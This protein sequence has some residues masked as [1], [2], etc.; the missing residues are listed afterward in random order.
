[1][2]HIKTHLQIR[3]IFLILLCTME[4]NQVCLHPLKLNQLFKYRI[5]SS[6]Q[7]NNDL[8]L[9]F[10]DIIRGFRGKT[11][12]DFSFFIKNKSNFLLS[13][14]RFNT[15]C[16][17][18]NPVVSLSCVSV[19]IMCLVYCTNNGGS[20]GQVI[21]TYQLYYQLYLLKIKKI[22]KFKQY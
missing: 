14:E 4:G 19:C 9:N 7:K 2:N 3:S 1:M 18:I 17:Q 16:Y 21:Q 8:F 20:S 12:S 15:T 13:S 22:I 5:T 11:D 10:T 6:M